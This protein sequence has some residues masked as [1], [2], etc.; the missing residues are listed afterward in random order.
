[1]IRQKKIETKYSEPMYDDCTL[2]QIEDQEAEQLIA[3]LVDYCVSLEKQV[4]G[5]RSQVNSLTPPGKPKPYFDLHGDLY[6]V[7]H[8]YA[9][10]SKFR[11]ILKLLD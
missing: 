11:Q 4:V 1:M 8:D 6:E 3:G 7:F 2:M 10:H 5:L 9:A